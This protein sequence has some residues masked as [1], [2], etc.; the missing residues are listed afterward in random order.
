MTKK[1]VLVQGAGCLVLDAG[2]RIYKT[3]TFAFDGA[4]QLVSS[5]TDGVG[6]TRVRPR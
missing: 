6:L 3:T 5:T 1:V 4:N 2:E